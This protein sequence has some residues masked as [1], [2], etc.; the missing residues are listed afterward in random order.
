MTPAL[1]WERPLGAAPRA[2]GTT[3][4]RVWAPRAGAV[5]VGAGGRAARSEPRGRA[6]SRAA[7]RPRPATTTATSWTAATRCPTPAR[8]SSPRAC[9]ARRASS[10]RPRSPGPTTAGPASTRDGL[11]VYE[12]HV[13]TFTPEGTFAAAAER[14]RRAARAGR[15]R[16]RA[17]AG[18]DLPRASATGATTASTPGP[19]TRPT[20]GRRGA[21]RASSTRPTRA[22][23][24][25]IL[26]VVYNHLGPG[27]RGPRGLRPVPHRPPRHALGHG[28][29]LRRRATAA[30]CASGRSRT[31]CMWVR[32]VPR[33][34]PAGGRGPRDLRPRARA[35]CWPSCATRARAA[36]PRPPLLI[37]ESDLNDPR[38]CIR[39]PEAGGWGFDAQWADDFH[40]ALHALLTG[41]RDGYYADFGSRRRPGARRRARPFVYDG[42]YSALP[43]PPP[44]RAGRRPAARA[45]SSSAPRTTTRWATAPLGDRLPPTAR[46]LAAAVDDPLPLHAHALHGRGARRASAPSSSSPTTST[47]SSPTPPARGGGASSRRSPASTG[48][49]A[50]PPGPG[51]RPAVGARPRRRR[52]GVR[53]LYRRLLALRREL[54][55][56]DADGAP[57]TTRRRWIAMRPRAAARWSGNFGRDEAEVPVEADASWCWR[58]TRARACAA[59]RLRLPA[60]AG[61]VVR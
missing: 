9:A 53:E 26:D 47:R 5:E 29:E 30:A 10:T 34:R 60:L 52:P 15:H 39:P 35:T 25:V 7:S 14:L 33:R 50:R 6:S 16:D 11:V 12:L 55:A 56:E 2:G 61:A 45:S 8:A 42:R 51:D 40:H 23:L 19:R 49:G 57:G 20:A 44:R 59:G 43:A 1:P 36:P 48:G 37:A 4:F 41:E 21:G 17:D 24:G 22:G 28:D 31:P 32:D 27:R 54:P 13:G 18:R 3:I 58:R 46:A 38:R